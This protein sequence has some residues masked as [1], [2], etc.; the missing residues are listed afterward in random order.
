MGFM[1]TLMTLLISW[2]YQKDSSWYQCRP[3][4]IC[5]RLLTL[6]GCKLLKKCLCGCCGRR[7]EMFTRS[8]DAK[9][10]DEFMYKTLSLET[11]SLSAVPKRTTGEMDELV[12]SV[13]ST[14]NTAETTLSHSESVTNGTTLLMAGDSVCGRHDDSSAQRH[15]L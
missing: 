13:V 12:S 5:C 10:Q 1:I 7:K 3:D 14:S 9:Y 4:S 8:K 6:C 11:T 2:I 15:S